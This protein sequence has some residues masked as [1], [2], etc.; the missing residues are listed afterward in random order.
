MKTYK[1]ELPGDEFEIITAKNDNEA[2]KEAWEL[3]KQYGI[4]CI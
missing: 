4:Q 3:E 1:L 2:M